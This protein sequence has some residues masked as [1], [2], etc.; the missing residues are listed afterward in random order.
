MFK[1]FVSSSLPIRRISQLLQTLLEK[2][3]AQ[4]NFF[5]DSPLS[6]ENDCQVKADLD[7][8]F[9]NSLITLRLQR[10]K[11]TTVKDISIPDPNSRHFVHFIS[12]F[13]LQ[14]LFQVRT[15]IKQKQ[16]AMGYLTHPVCHTRHLGSSVIMRVP[17]IQRQMNKG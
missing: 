9:A 6:S 17:D 10:R 13:T 16:C 2:N 3:D 8:Y 4:F 7:K 1:L 11:I 15:Y 14:F 5:K 12:L